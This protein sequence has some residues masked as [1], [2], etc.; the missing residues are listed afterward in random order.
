[1]RYAGLLVAILVGLPAVAAA[2]TADV[3]IVVKVDLQRTHPGAPPDE[4]LEPAPAIQ[5]QA[6]DVVASHPV[7]RDVTARIQTSEAAPNPRVPADFL[8]LVD[9]RVDDVVVV[10]LG[11]HV[12]LDSFQAS[13]RAGIQ[14]YVAVFN[15]AARRK[16]ASRQFNIVAEYPGDVPREAVVQA[17]LA[18]R[19]RGAAVPVEE[20]ELGLLDAAVK[21]RLGRELAAALA[22]YH[23]ASLPAVSR[24]AVEDA[25]RRMAQYLADSPDRRP[26]AIVMLEGY[27][28]RF[29]DS[30]HRAEM[31]R[32]LQRLKQTAARD[33]A[34]DRDRQRE[35]ATNHVAQTLTAAQ[36]TQ[37]FEKLIGSVVEV[38]AFRL[39]WRD[40]G[41]AVM[42]PDSK[43]QTLLVT[44]TPN[45]ARELDADPEPIY[46]LV[47][48][49]EP[50]FL[51]VKVPV[52]RWVGCPKTSCPK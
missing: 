9:Q 44:G 45:R 3:H 10:E 21:E 13:G 27:L 29:P 52:V 2:R 38:R 30:P 1:M 39:D 4:P 20:V 41:T 46:V 47:V 28:T 17:E 40:D 49:R 7:F 35:R 14:G 25:M 34:Q 33:P 23:P 48:G 43:G 16:V 8:R 15:V 19:A 5:Q 50:R 22:V 51:D 42:T 6:R 36:L 24:Q 31:E 12:R 26:E 11:Y 37:L 18:A 32:R